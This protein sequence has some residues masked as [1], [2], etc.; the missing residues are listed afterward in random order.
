MYFCAGNAV[1]GVT[2]IMT[3]TSHRLSC[4]CTHRVWRNSVSLLP[5]NNISQSGMQYC[6]LHALVDHICFPFIMQAIVSSFSIFLILENRH[7]LWTTV[8]ACSHTVVEVS[9]IFLVVALSV[10]LNNKQWTYMYFN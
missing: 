1:T 8:Y 6:R 9:C 10:L 5:S 2:N 3:P 7:A 4:F